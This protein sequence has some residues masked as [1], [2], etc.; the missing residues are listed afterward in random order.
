ME[1]S[2]S[3]GSVVAILGLI[4]GL[5][6]LLDKI[7]TEAVKKQV[8][9][10][11]VSFWVQAD[12]AKIQINNDWS[13]VFISSFDTFF[14]KELFSWRRVKGSWAISTVT[15]IVLTVV[16]WILRPEQ[17]ASLLDKTGKDINGLFAG[18][19]VTAYI[20]NLIP[21]YFSAI[22]TRLLMGLV[23]R[24]KSLVYRAVLLLVDILATGLLFYTFFFV[25]LYFF[26]EIYGVTKE[27]RNVWD[28]LKYSNPQDTFNFLIEYGPSLTSHKLGNPSIGIF[29]YSTYFSTVWLFGLFLVSLSL[30]QVK[31][32]FTLNKQLLMLVAE[33]VSETDKPFT[34]IG[35]FIAFL[36]VIIFILGRLLF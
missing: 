27:I 29:L 34:V 6:S 7:S 4:A 25:F 21:D 14:G 10:W 18:V 1:I 22:Q 23:A 5:F 30:F 28:A 3:L 8:K 35:S 24:T 11:L 16:W 15:I 2:E 33:K 36:G 19:L 9:E 12:D 13:D 32:I 17:F 26:L 20:L 31:F